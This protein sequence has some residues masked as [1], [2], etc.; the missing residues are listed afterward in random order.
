M[1]PT[2]ERSIYPIAIASVTLRRALELKMKNI[3]QVIDSLPAKRRA[4]V[5]A[6]R[7]QLISRER[8]RI[9]KGRRSSP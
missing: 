2:V 5:M 6:R 8:Q 1:K 4:R 3:N 7:R 9:R